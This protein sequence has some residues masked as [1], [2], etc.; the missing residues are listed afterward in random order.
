MRQL[1]TIEKISEVR[2]IENSDFLQVAMMEGLG[3]ECVVNKKDGFKIG[4]L[5]CYIQTDS[6]TPERPE[7]EFLRE[8]GFK[9]KIIKLR[10]QI[11]EGLIMP[12]SILPK[13]ITPV[14]G[15]DVTE[16]LGIIHYQKQIEEAE[17]QGLA[18]NFK[19]KSKT[20]TFLMQFAIFRW[21]YFKLNHVDKGWPQWISHTDELRFQVCVK[22]LI[23][24]MNKLWY[25][26][27]KVD[28]QSGTFFYHKSKKCGIPNWF[29]G[30]CSRNIWIKK[31]NES[32]YWRM[33]K[34]YDLEKKLS[35]LKKEVVIQGECTGVAIQDNKY[36]LSEVD[37]FVFNVILDGK[38]CSIKEMESFCHA[39]GLKTVPIVDRAF[40][41]ESLGNISEIRDVVQA[42]LKMSNGISQLNSNTIR[43]GIVLRLIE[44][45]EISFKAISPEFDLKY[46]S[47]KKEKK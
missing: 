20:L 1:A 30:V 33:A 35:E 41:P 29:F 39:M 22:K 17:E 10:K 2:D 14:Q 28:G 38:R 25:I 24:N 5:V 21:I 9:V 47:H 16:T 36:A 32:S 13:N 44:N 11:S 15:L 46:N 3:W 40:N 26:S 8:R 7:F 31:P 23:N 27:E 6:K 12:L 43:E 18:K 4:D 34:K 37:F 19:S 45:P 42:I